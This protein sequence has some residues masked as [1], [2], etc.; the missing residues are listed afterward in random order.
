MNEIYLRTLKTPQFQEKIK[1]TSR[2]FKNIQLP[3]QR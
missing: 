1:E 3:E 2:L